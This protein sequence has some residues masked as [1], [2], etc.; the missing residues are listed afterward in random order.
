MLC[1][2]DC[3]L[4]TG[5]YQTDSNFC[6]CVL[7]VGHRNPVYPALARSLHP[8]A[9]CI[10]CSPKSMPKWLKRTHERTPTL[11]V[12]GTGWPGVDRLW[13]D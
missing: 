9:N 10:A 1:T 2:A 7:V 6:R 3:L 13:K 11:V 12:G 4:P 8:I 5:D